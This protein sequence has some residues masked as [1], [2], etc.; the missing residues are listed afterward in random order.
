MELN[1]EEINHKNFER[2]KETLFKLVQEI[3]SEKSSYEN[4][5]DSILRWQD[6]N[7]S[8][9]YF[10]ILQGSDKIGLTGYW[11][12]KQEKGAF[13]LRHHGTKIKG[14][15]EKSL[16]L[17]IT[18]LKNK[19]KKEFKYLFELVPKGKENLIDKFKEWG[20]ELSERGVPEWEPKK[21]YYKYL[22]IKK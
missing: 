20:F 1:L 12:I 16:Y 17:L 4:A 2:E 22:M 14:T 18:Y 5:I 13:G 15:G 3:W 9:N 11:P 19:Y 21:D 7:E 10:Y 8:G 6:N